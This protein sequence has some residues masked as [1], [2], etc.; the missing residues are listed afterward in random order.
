MAENVAIAS[1]AGTDDSAEI[2]IE[3]G[4]SVLF[5]MDGAIEADEF[6][7][8]YL[9]KG[10]SKSTEKL[11]D[12]KPELSPIT[13]SAARPMVPLSGPLHVFAVKSATNGAKALKYYS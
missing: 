10:G 8:F 12:S 6:V 3:S 11:K 2:V 7:E 4:A 9:S 13:M 1:T 5:F